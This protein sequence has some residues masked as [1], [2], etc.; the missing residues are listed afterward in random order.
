MYDPATGAV[1]HAGC[2][3][4]LVTLSGRALLADLLTGAVSGFAR[5][6][7][8]L[9]GPPEPTDFTYA[10]RQAAPDDTALEHELVAVP[11]TRGPTTEQPDEGGHRRMVTP[12][13]ATLEAV[14]GG[15][16]LVLMEAG[17]KLT[18]SDGA[19]VLYNRVVFDRITKKSNLE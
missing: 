17:I 12:V 16:D 18:K 13:S 19:S 11:A 1:V 6:E 4:N 2:I 3:R 14:A 9:G 5:V 8:A 7:L 15:D 10:P